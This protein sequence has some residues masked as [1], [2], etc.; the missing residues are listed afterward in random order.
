MAGFERDVKKKLKEH[1]F[2]LERRPRGSHDIWGNGE[3]EISVPA[4]IKK[5]HTA[6]GIL[7]EA[8]IDAKS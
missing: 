7:K 8:G 3:I 6:N 5:R 4:R 1:G 2:A